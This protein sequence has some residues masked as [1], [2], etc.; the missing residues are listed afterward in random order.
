MNKTFS[1]LNLFF[2]VFVVCCL[3]IFTSCTPV[4]NVVYFQNL[5]KDTTLHN[6]VSN[7]LELKIRKNDLLSIAIISPDPVSTPLFNG[8]PGSSASVAGG[9]FT[10]GY[11]VDNNG[12]V[13]IYKLGV[14]HVEG[15]TRNELKLRLQKDLA[16]YLVDAVV[17]VRFL[18]NRVTM[19]GEFAHPGIVNMPNEQISLLEAIGLSGDLTITGR[20]ENILV[21]RESPAGKQFKRL[22]LTDNSIFSSPFYYLKPDDVVYVE[23]T[24]V[25]IKNTVQTQQTVGY[26]LSG[27]TIL[28][29]ILNLTRK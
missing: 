8:I 26:I 23:P 10:G 12:N 5:Q 7:N 6:L 1:L 3:N 29:T 21:I 28:I 18:S 17:T 14:V 9:A 19:L 24:K 22:N 25:K 15:L 11:L 20:R 4:K 13:V 16:P 27:V 2:S